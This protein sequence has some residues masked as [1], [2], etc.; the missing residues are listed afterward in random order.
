MTLACAK[1]NSRVPAPGRCLGAWTKSWAKG[2][3]SSPPDELRLMARAVENMEDLDN[4]PG[5]AVIDQ[6]LSRREAACAGCDFVASPA[7]SGGLAQEREMLLES[8]DKPV[9]YFEAGSLGPINKDFI[10][11]AKGVL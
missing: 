2:L 11:F 3:H 9:G 8:L 4:F 7:D 5:F 10:Q 6:I 1:V